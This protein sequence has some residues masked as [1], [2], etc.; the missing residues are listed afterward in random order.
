MTMDPDSSTVFRRKLRGLLL[1]QNIRAI[2]RESGIPRTTLQGL[3]NSNRQPHASTVQRIAR[4]LHVDVG[5]LLDDSRRWPPV[6]PTP[7][8]PASKHRDDRDA[9][10]P[11]TYTATETRRA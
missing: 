7:P 6:P 3:L 5:W 10:A 8:V 2:A 11:S 1:G 4:A 9:A